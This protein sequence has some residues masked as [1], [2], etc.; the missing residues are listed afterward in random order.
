MILLSVDQ[1][2]LIPILGFE[3]L[4]P[5]DSA[6]LCGSQFFCLSVLL[7]LSDNV[8]VLKIVALVQ[9][10]NPLIVGKSINYMD[11]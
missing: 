1:Y 11:S 9:N 8:Q 4:R 7:L 10:S 3:S 5:R 2:F 6:L